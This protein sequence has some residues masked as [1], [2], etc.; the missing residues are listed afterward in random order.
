[1]I[2]ETKNPFEPGDDARASQSE[3][4]NLSA[5]LDSINIVVMAETQH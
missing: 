5:I 4:F 3:G 1:M 2:S